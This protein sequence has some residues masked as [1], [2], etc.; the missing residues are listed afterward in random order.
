M[1]ERT[2]MSADTYEA[3]PDGPITKPIHIRHHRLTRPVFVCPNDTLHVTVHD[4]LGKQSVHFPIVQSMRVTHV[5]K[6]EIRD[7]FGYDV[8]VGAVIGQ[9]SE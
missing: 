6:F 5:T 7:E 2:N 4:D 3:P 1:T 9:R 8:G